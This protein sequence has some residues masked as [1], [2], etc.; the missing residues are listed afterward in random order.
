M[1]PGCQF[2]ILAI[3]SACT[4][5]LA[6]KSLRSCSVSAMADRITYLISKD[7]E[8]SKLEVT[9][10]ACHKQEFDCKS[11]HAS[12]APQRQDTN[13]GVEICLRTWHRY[14]E[15]SS[16]MADEEGRSCLLQSDTQSQVHSNH[17]HTRLTR[18][19]GHANGSLAPKSGEWKALSQRT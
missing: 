17:H 11:V 2:V 12:L 9:K 7:Q 18:R 4:A 15:P 14:A 13:S 5:N 10:E 19:A 1:P 8:R 6:R 16:H 3:T